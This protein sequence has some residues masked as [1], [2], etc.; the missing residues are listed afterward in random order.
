MKNQ[1]LNTINDEYRKY[2]EKWLFGAEDEISFWKMYMENRGGYI[3]MGLKERFL[4]TEHLNWRTT[5]RLRAMEKNISSLMQA[6][7]HFRDV[8]G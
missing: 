6:P 5:Y 1:M 8:E 7:V 3:F 4:Q 2:Y